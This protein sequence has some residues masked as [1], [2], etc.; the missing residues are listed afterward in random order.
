[1]NLIKNEESNNNINSNKNIKIIFFI[2]IIKKISN[3]FILN[4]KY[5]FLDILLKEWYEIN[6]KIL[7]EKIDN[8]SNINSIFIYNSYKN[9]IYIITNIINKYK[10]IYSYDFIYNIQNILFKK[11]SLINIIQ[12]EKYKN[13][14]KK[15]NWDLF[16]INNNIINKDE[17]NE[18]NFLFDKESNRFKKIVS[19]I[20]VDKFIYRNI[21]ILNKE[22][23]I[24][25]LY[26]KNK[27]NNNYNENIYNNIYI[28][29][30]FKKW[31]KITFKDASNLYK[32]YFTK[33][34]YFQCN[35]IIYIYKRRIKNIFNIFINNCKKYYSY[36][37]NNNE[38]NKILLN[39]TISLL[40]S[41][42]KCY[43]NIKMIPYN[44]FISFYYSITK[45][46]IF[47]YSILY[48]IN[49]Y[50]LRYKNN[51][52]INL[53]LYD[54]KKKDKIKYFS[55]ILSSIFSF[56][57]SKIISLFIHSLKNKI[58]YDSY[59]DKFNI[60]QYNN[61]SQI[62]NKNIYT[63]FYYKN[64]QKII[65]II[66]LYNKYTTLKNFKIFKSF[67]NCFIKWKIITTKFLYNDYLQN[68][69]IIKKKIKEY[70]NNNKVTQNKIVKL[71][72]QIKDKKRKKEK[73]EKINQ[74][75]IRKKLNKKE[76]EKEK[77]KKENLMEKIMIS[78][79]RVIDTNEIDK[80]FDEI[81]LN[82]LENLESL[83]N[84]NEPII[85]NLQ[86]EINNLVKEIDILS[87][88]L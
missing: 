7:Q 55:Y 61:K 70:T 82:Y 54:N 79:N 64:Q 57:K 75:N 86:N 43:N 87:N 77:E 63:F 44:Y 53:K 62:I 11:K 40:L 9:I 85:E 66:L 26:I 51:F 1:M 60:K 24:N 47:F 49:R 84:K 23:S 73:K 27:Y 17:F 56:K 37:L 32:F 46:I 34:K 68:K 41:I 88:D 16:K 15:I 48:F 3:D 80:Y 22:I 30:Y 8:L 13:I 81:S 67:K 2:K 29:K 25:I 76:K 12:N 10:I 6:N 78:E 18:I 39:N 21:K 45:Y 4:Y 58:L 19:D 52:I 31:E 35:N 33:F 38:K 69:Y 20:F 71:N 36:N 42:K 5:I 65:K 72:K 14:I 59:I 50:L 74:R 83:K 28:Y